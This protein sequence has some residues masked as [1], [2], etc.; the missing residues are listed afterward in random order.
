MH[1]LGSATYI[2]GLERRQ[3]GALS[4]YY[5]LY[6]AAVGFNIVFLPLF[7]KSRGLSLSQMAVLWATAAVVGGLAQ[8]RVGHWSDSIGSRKAL[9]AGGIALLGASYFFYRYAHTFW[10]FVPLYLWSG[11]WSLIGATLPQAMISDWTSRAGST[12]RAFAV[13][14]IWGSIGFIAALM[15]ATR[16]P[17]VAVGIRP[18]YWVGGLYVAS[19]LPLLFIRDASILKTDHSL[20]RGAMKVLRSNRCWAFLACL[21]VFKLT[22]TGLANYMGLFLKQLGAGPGLIAAAYWAS[23]VAEVPF[24]LAIG[25]IS[26][27]VGRR[28]PL[29]AAFAVW[30][31]R[32][33]AY[34]LISEPTSVFYI[35]L[36]HGLTYG[37][38]V[39]CAVAYMSDV[40]PPDLRG[41]AQ[42]LLSIVSAVAMAAGP[43]LAGL[44]GDTLGL[45]ATFRVM[46]G[47]V[48]LALV[49][50]ILFVREPKATD[51]V[52]RDAGL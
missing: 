6:F 12:G 22:E 29:I 2:H 37:I 52:V 18:L 11:M 7:L 5:L 1:K 4:L 41:T 16:W 28:I 32:L 49:V 20:L 42:G 24:L 46:S 26:D 31:L 3:A 34:S 38:S 23:A 44:L 50:V 17:Q 30:S 10:Q 47:L 36:F 39:V 13:V 27:R 51:K 19:A 15:M 21:T 43:L 9:A 25:R 8:W 33:L 14:R 40:A 48:G 35:Q 45:A